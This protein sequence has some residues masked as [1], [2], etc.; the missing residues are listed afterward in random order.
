MQKHPI[1]KGSSTIKLQ[2]GSK[3]N[4]VEKAGCGSPREWESV[5]VLLWRVGEG[6]VRPVGNGTLLVMQV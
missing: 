2:E 3:E 6:W 4:G 5:A 1:I